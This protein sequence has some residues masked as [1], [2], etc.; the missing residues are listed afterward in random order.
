M[1]ADRLLDELL[2]AEGIGDSLRTSQR[3]Q[4]EFAAARLVYSL[5]FT[6]YNVT[7]STASET[8]LGFGY[9]AEGHPQGADRL[10]HELLDTAGIQEFVRTIPH[11]PQ[12]EF[13]AARV[14][15]DGTL[16][17]VDVRV[18]PDERIPRSEDA[19]RRVD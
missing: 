19:T 16:Y 5:D 3:D 8:T 10:L 4:R 14:L 6:L 2:A 7:V 13:A 15:Y 12:H 1:D 11:D 18:A 9:E 17:N